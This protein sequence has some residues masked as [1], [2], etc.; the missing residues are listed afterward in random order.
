MNRSQRHLTHQRL[1]AFADSSSFLSST[2]HQ[3]ISVASPARLSFLVPLLK[4]SELWSFFPL[5]DRC[6]FRTAHCYHHFNTNH[7]LPPQL[8]LLLQYWCTARQHLWLL[9]APIPQACRP[10]VLLISSFSLSFSLRPY[11]KT[12]SS[13]FVFLRHSRFLSARFCPIFSYF[14]FPLP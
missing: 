13:S 2:E 4:F 7:G 9:I 10:R 14:S 11:Q 8:Q 1:L 3:A 12:Y 5:C 6:P